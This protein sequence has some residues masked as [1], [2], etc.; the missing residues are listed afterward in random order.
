[1]IVGQMLVLIMTMAGIYY[2]SAVAAAMAA[3]EAQNNQ[4]HSMTICNP[5]EHLMKSRG[6]V[7]KVVNVTEAALD[8]WDMENPIPAAAIASAQA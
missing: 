5:L 4:I 7:V 6:D 2:N 8:I 1:L 3:M